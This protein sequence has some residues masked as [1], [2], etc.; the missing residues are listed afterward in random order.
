MTMSHHNTTHITHSTPCIAPPA[1]AA[2]RNS[3]PGTFPFLNVKTYYP[4]S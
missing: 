2:S 1:A 3:P 4:Y